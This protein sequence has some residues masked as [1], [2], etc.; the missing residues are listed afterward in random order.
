[1]S[2]IEVTLKVIPR[3]E[4]NLKVTGYLFTSLGC[5]S[6]CK[7]ADLS[8]FDLEYFE[9]KV[10]ARLP[11]LEASVQLAPVCVARTERKEEEK[12]ETRG[13]SETTK[14]EFEL[15]VGQR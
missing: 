11:L 6:H 4:G 13:E 14:V 12:E 2:S 10:I 15:F 5:R 7:F 3:S 9:V 1:M 8:H